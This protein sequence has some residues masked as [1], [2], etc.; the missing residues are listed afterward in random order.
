[1]NAKHILHSVLILFLI[2]CFNKQLKC[3]ENNSELR[4]F[5]TCNMAGYSG[6]TEGYSVYVTDEQ[7]TQIYAKGVVGRYVYGKGNYFL[8][9]I[10]QSTKLMLICFPKNVDFLLGIK[11]FSI[12]PTE[13]DKR[14][15]LNITYTRSNIGNTGNISGSGAEAIVRLVQMVTSFLVQNQLNKDIEF[16]KGLSSYL[17]DLEKKQNSKISDAKLESSSTGFFKS[18]YSLSD[19]KFE[20]VKNSANT[21][22]PTQMTCKYPW[23]EREVIILIMQ[24]PEIWTGQE[25]MHGLITGRKETGSVFQESLVVSG[26]KVFANG[27]INSSTQAWVLLEDNF[28]AVITI[29]KGGDLNENLKILNFKN[30]VQIYHKATNK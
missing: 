27:L 30:F 8:S 21:P 5:I 25:R 12:Q 9:G 7:I 26:Y 4:G 6:V 2:I 24:S 15:D 18:E 3:Q 13:I 11:P 19:P 20:I 16:N 23:K 29:V 1:M 14:V 28:L 17:M 22:N 10:P